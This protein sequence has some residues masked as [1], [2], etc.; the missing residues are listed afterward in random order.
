[1]SCP[2]MIPVII[3][4]TLEEQAPGYLNR[5]TRLP[6]TSL[7]Y[8]CPPGSCPGIPTPLSKPQLHPAIAA[9]APVQKRTAP[10]TSHCLP[11]TLLRPRPIRKLLGN[12]A[13]LVPVRATSTPPTIDDDDDDDDSFSLGLD[14]S[15]DPATLLCK[16]LNRIEEHAWGFD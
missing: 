11:R 2:V 3:E 10:P 1:M 13:F 5:S 7:L 14:F 8:Q 15:R 4:V 16:T 12:H 9:A 6:Q